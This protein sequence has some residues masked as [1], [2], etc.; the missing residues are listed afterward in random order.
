MRN[1]HT[2][3]FL[4]RPQTEGS[5]AERLEHALVPLDGSERAE[6]ELDLV[7][8]LSGSLIRAITLLRV[9]PRRGRVASEQSVQEATQ[10]LQTVNERL[11]DQV[12]G[13]AIVRTQVEVGDP[14][15]RI[16]QRAKSDCDLLIMATHG[17]IGARR[18]AFG[19][20]ADRVLHDSETPL[21]LVVPPPGGER[22]THQLQSAVK[23]HPGVQS[24][25]GVAMNTEGERE[26]EIERMASP[27]PETQ[28]RESG[29]PGSGAGRTDVPGHTGV[30]P[31]SAS[32]GASGEAPVRRE[33][34]WGQGERGAAG[35]EDSGDSS[36][37]AFMEPQEGEGQRG[38]SATAPPPSE[39]A[40]H[41]AL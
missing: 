3:V 29:Q 12:T 11:T 22:L 30:Y 4:L 40:P 25:E 39:G 27:S 31:L 18:W 23:A 24:W 16:I 38:R 41:G 14:A 21:L 1:S 9:V 20:V 8:A 35:Y 33:P 5:R 2:P 13:R 26:R 15:E 28:A 10:Y 7:E 19:S 32:E 37:D 34:A 17:E 36:L 6:A